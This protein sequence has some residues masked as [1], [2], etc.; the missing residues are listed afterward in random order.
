MATDVLEIRDLVAAVRQRRA[1]V[2]LVDGVSLRI[3][4][5]TSV[6]LVGESG[7][8]KSMTALS[9][10]KLLPPSV[11]IVSGQIL[12]NGRDLVPLGDAGMRKIRAREVA[13]IFQDPMSSLTPTMTIGRQVAEAVRVHSGGS[14]AE[15]ER[16]VV[17]L[18][19]MVG[20]PRPAERLKTYPHQLSGGQRQRVM[21]AMALAGGAELL[22]ADEPT[23]ALDVTIQA[24]ILDLLDDLE[25]R[26]GMALLLITH[27]MGVIA[28]RCDRVVVMYAGQVVEN[29][30]TAN[31]FAACRHPYT[32]ALLALIPSLD[33][34]AGQVL[35]TIPGVPPEP[36]AFPPG[37][38]F[39]PRC[40]YSTEVCRVEQP[41]LDDPLGT[42]HFFACHHPLGID[43]QAP[44]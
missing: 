13:M 12:I 16:R 10:L 21:I 39:A 15:T 19:S 9:I 22:I 17:E 44:P 6:G 38:R 18:L 2:P 33:A 34:D 1:V 8:G 32:A 41:S 26:L 14:R 20:F 28:S 27:D 24:Q 25:Q 4:R 43:Q 35:P 3:G 11:E 5:A 36:S 40:R 37:C 31:L 30:G 23:T 42:G 7:S 29:A